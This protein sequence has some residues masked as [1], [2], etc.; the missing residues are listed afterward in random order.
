MASTGE[1]SI[2]AMERITKVLKKGNPTWSTAKNV[3]CS[4]S[5]TYKPNGKG[6]D[7]GRPRKMSKR[8][9]RKLKVVCPKNRKYSTKQ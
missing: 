5:L 8:K 1:L 3:G 2:K 9:D 7:M 6:K 4:Q